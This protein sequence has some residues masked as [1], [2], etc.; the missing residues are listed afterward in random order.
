MHL[1]ARNVPQVV[2]FSRINRAFSVINSTGFSN[3]LVYPDHQSSFICLLHPTNQ[4]RLKVLTYVHGELASESILVV[5]VAAVAASQCRR[6]GVVKWCCHPCDWR[7][8]FTLTNQILQAL[9][10]L[11]RLTNRHTQNDIQIHTHTHTHSGN[12]QNHWSRSVAS[13]QSRSQPR[14]LQGLG[15]AAGTCVQV[16][17]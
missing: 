16:T 9:L 11:R 8:V 6:P 17:S 14:W 13:Q 10:Q 3:L 15:V 7:T 2:K 1:S 12:T 5:S 4:P